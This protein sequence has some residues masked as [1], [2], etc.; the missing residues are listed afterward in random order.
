MRRDDR[1]GALRAADEAEGVDEARLH[2]RRQRDAARARH[3]ADDPL[4]EGRAYRGNG[5]DVSQSAN[6]GQLEHDDVSHEQ[7]GQ[8]HRIH[9]VQRVIV[10]REHQADADRAA[11]H[12]AAHARDRRPVAKLLVLPGTHGGQHLSREGDRPVEL[13]R[14]VARRLA[15][16]PL[17]HLDDLVAGRGQRVE[18]RLESPTPLAERQLRPFALPAVPRRRCRFD[19]LHRPVAVVCR[20]STHDRALPCRRVDDG[21]QDF[22]DTAGP[23][24]EFAA[25][26]HFRPAVHER[27]FP[28]RRDRRQFRALELRRPR[29]AHRHH[30][31]HHHSDDAHCV[32][33]V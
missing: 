15:N 2:E 30:A 24:C 27:S 20:E 7:R 25:H 29:Q 10:R 13:F 12:F 17:Q 21:R 16:F 1:V 8:H 14:R 3:K 23:F 28:R 4:G 6:V 5:Q 11:S 19:R 22:V 31:R 32:T 18:V 26:K 9:L 33:S